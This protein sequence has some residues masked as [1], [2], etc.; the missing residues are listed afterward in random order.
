M[1]LFLNNKLYINVRF[2]LLFIILKVRY[3]MAD[4]AITAT[5]A[6]TSQAVNPYGANP[7]MAND[8]FGSQYFG[9]VFNSAS[10]SP[11]FMSKAPRNSASA[12]LHAYA[13]ANGGTNIGAPTMQDYYLATQIANQFAN[14]QYLISPYSSFFQN[15]AF[16]QKLINP[17]LYYTA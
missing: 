8:L 4:N 17:G 1:Q 3:F 5:N 13:N 7:S 6:V 10:N 14:N 12:L 2:S 11:S 16:A 15:D 9:T